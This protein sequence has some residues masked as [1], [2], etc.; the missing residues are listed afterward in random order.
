M[1]IKTM[2]KADK[3]DA[4]KMIGEYA[5]IAFTLLGVLFGMMIMTFIFGQ[6]G[7]D[8][9]SIAAATETVAVTNETGAWLNQTAYTVSNSGA[10]G[11]A[12]LVITSAINTTDNSSIAVGNFT[13]SEATFTN[14]SVTT[15]PSVWVSYTYTQDT[16]AKKATDQVQNNSLVAITTYT[17]GASTQL[18]TVSIAIILILL[19]GVFLVFWKIF[20]TNKK[21]RDTSGGNFG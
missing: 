21:S 11:F 17:A 3:M 4:G 6:L 7:S 16:D 2:T 20:V 15:W 12:S 19:I 14:A 10:V 9:I 1:Y 8:N 13:V 18:N 5:G